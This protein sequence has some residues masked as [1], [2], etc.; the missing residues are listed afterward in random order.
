MRTCCACGQDSAGRL[1]SARGAGRRVHESA[2][3]PCAGRSAR[4][5]QGARY[6]KH[7]SCDPTPPETKT[8]A[9]P[10]LLPIFATP[11]VVAPVGGASDL[12]ASL[13]SLFLGRATE[14]Y[15]DPTIRPD[16]LCFRSRK[17][18][19]EWPEP[20]VG[21]LRGQ[22]LGGIWAA[23]M[24]ANRRTCSRRT[25]RACRSQS[26]LVSPDALRGL[27][28]RPQPSPRLLVGRVLRA[29]R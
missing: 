27:L 21:H 10:S 2:S 28:H 24:A 25:W 1:S 14:E 22:L 7:P 5:P 19:F 8:M 26:H 13:A 4:A 18:L 9:T 16:P 15:R 29:R 3:D 20:A 23:V 11:F 17:E 12:N 6:R